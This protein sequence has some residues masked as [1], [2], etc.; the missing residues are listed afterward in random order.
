M[1]IKVIVLKLASIFSFL[2]IASG[3]PL[4]IYLNSTKGVAIF[5]PNNINLPLFYGFLVCVGAIGI[6][7]KGPNITSPELDLKFAKVAKKYYPVVLAIAVTIQLAV[8][9]FFTT[10]CLNKW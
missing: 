10:W 2:I 6:L 3:F 9:L 7:T 1:S 4:V 8:L 5:Y